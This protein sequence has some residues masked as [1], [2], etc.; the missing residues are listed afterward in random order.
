MMIP[1]SASLLRQFHNKHHCGDHTEKRKV[2]RVCVEFAWAHW[3]ILEDIR[4]RLKLIRI[5][6]FQFLL[7]WQDSDVI[8]GSLQEAGE[9]VWLD[10]RDGRGM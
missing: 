2:N 10:E 4:Q 1:K 9:I 5:Y 7:P 3:S 6:Q 8:D